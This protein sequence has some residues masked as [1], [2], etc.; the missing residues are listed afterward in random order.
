ML[1]RFRMTCPGTSKETD[2][3]LSHLGLSSHLVN[4]TSYQFF[5]F[6]HRLN[7]AFMI[8]GDPEFLPFN[9]PDRI[10]Y[11]KYAPNSY[12]TINGR[13]LNRVCRERDVIGK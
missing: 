8:Y 6:S 4:L 10:K 12:V 13:D 11:Y 9:E 5:L 2:W 1:K 3:E 7:I